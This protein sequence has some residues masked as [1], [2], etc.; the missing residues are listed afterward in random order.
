MTHDTVAAIAT[1]AG[2]GGIGIVRVSG[3]QALAFAETI[4]RKKLT[5]RKAIFSEFYDDKGNIIDEGVVIFFVSPHSF[6]GE[7]VVEFQG[8]GSPIVLTL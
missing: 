8:H 2:R 3:S 5:A 7:D 4:T 1:P 6:T